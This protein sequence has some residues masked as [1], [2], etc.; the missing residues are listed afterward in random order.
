M[1]DSGNTKFIVNIF[2]FLATLLEHFAST[3][4]PYELWDCESAVLIPT[5][6]EK[7]GL[8]NATLKDKAKLL[9]KMTY[10]ICDKQKAYSYFIQSL[11][12]KNAKTKS[13]TL[14]LIVQFVVEFGINY[15]SEKEFKLFAKL[16]DSTDKGI[17]ENTVNLIGEVFN[18]LGDDIWRILGNLNPKV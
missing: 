10:P 3:D 1:L 12:S 14:D 13:E 6:C 7:T 2:D 8:N 16:A 4:P 15:S 5:L 18:H 9:V 11:N 17:R